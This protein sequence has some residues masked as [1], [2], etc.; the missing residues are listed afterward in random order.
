M[1][2]VWEAEI[3]LKRY[4]GLNNDDPPVRKVSTIS[5]TDPMMMALQ[6]QS[7]HVGK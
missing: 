3:K 4:K 5:Q 1:T 6:G 2:L 7:V